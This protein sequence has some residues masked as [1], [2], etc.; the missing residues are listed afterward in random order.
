MAAPFVR[1]VHLASTQSPAFLLDLHS[2]LPNLETVS[3]AF[4]RPKDKKAIEKEKAEK[5]KKA[6]KSS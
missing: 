2:L 3:G 4:K 6:K 1:K 5:E